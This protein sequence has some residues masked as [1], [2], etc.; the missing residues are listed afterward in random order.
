MYK[1]TK[2]EFIQFE[3]VDINVSYLDYNTKVNS[4]D[5]YGPK[6]QFYFSPNSY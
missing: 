4:N 1:E 3:K 6:P 5:R 2:S